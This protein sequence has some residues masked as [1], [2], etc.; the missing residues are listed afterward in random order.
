MSVTDIV[1]DPAA[2]TMTVTAELDAPVERV[3]QLWADPRQLERWWGPPSYPATVVDHDLRVGGRV[4]YFMTGALAPEDRRASERELLD[5]YVGALA[6]QGA[7]APSLDRAWRDYRS[8][9]LHGFL[10]AVTPAAMQPPESVLAMADR[11]LTAIAELGTLEL[12]S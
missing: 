4:A 7:A 8:F 12:L 2:A 10:W 3:W 6:A 1:K 5:H 11:H 9:A